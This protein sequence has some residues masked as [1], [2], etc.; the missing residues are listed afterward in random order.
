MDGETFEFMKAWEVVEGQDDMNFLRSTWA[1]KVKCDPY[2]LIKKYKDCFCA[3][4]DMQLEGIEFF[5]IYSPVVQCT[6]VIFMLILEVLLGLKSNQGDVTEA[7]I[8]VRLG[9][10]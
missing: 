7:S 3:R 9:E 4:G 1:F 2:G 5:K 8:H 10:D 6:T